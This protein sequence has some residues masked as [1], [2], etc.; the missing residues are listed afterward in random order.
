MAKLETLKDLFIDELRDLYSAENLLLLA[1]AKWADA[2]NSLDL[3]AAFREHRTQTEGQ[4]KRLET[5]FSE[6][7][8]KPTGKTSKGMVGLVTEGY[9]VIH[10][11]AKPEIKDSGLIAAAQRA[12]HYEIAG[13]GTART[14]AQHLKMTSEASLLELTLQEEE[15]TDKK[16][17]EHAENILNMLED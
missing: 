15:A 4:V 17:T 10:D 1:L 6:L 12:E 3:R 16:L 9:Q 8:E 5:I 13:Y 14:Y 7:E 2:A 11:R